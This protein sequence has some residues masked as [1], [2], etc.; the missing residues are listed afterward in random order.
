[1]YKLMQGQMGVAKASGALRRYRLDRADNS[2][3]EEIL[4]PGSH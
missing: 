1:M 3:R 4:D 2:S